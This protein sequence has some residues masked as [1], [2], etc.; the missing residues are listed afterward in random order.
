MSKKFNPKEQVSIHNE[1]P[2]SKYPIPHGTRV[3]AMSR[4]G[5][6]AGHIT[7]FHPSRERDASC[8][9]TPGHPWFKVE[10]KDLS[11][12]GENFVAD[13]VRRKTSAGLRDLEAVRIREYAAYA[14]RQAAAAQE[15]TMT[16]MASR[17]KWCRKW[18]LKVFPDAT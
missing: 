11:P 17:K 15:A 12:H 1:W 18:N 16:L 3:W 4:H 14:N 7:W 6:Y 10:G 9:C 13:Y 5:I 8:V 2:R